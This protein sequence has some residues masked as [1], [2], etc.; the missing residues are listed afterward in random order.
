VQSQRLGEVTYTAPGTMQQA[1]DFCVKNLTG[2]GWREPPG[3]RR[4][5]EAGGR[6]YQAFLFTK[7]GHILSATIFAADKGVGVSLRYSGNFDTRTLPRMKDAV[8]TAGGAGS[9]LNYTVTNYTTEASVNDVIDFLAREVASLGWQEYVA[10]MGSSRRSPGSLNF[11]K[12]A[13]HVA[14]YAF[15]DREKPSKTTVSYAADVLTDDFPTMPDAV[16]LRLQDG[17]VFEFRYE[18]PAAYQTVIDFYK[19]ELHAL[20]WKYRE[21]AGL[22]NKDSTFFFFDDSNKHYLSVDLKP[23]AAGK[24]LVRFA[25]LTP[26]IDAAYE[27][28]L[29]AP[30]TATAPAGWPYRCWYWSHSMPLPAAC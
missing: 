19:K 28:K 16:S 17:A 1:A 25:H 9:F 20:G 30:K 27:Q 14:I 26:E 3:E 2:A 8:L 24:T 22:F 10:H 23:A 7:Q 13:T 11:R 21:G 29:K 18:T 15:K 5:N 6:E 4:K 12:Q